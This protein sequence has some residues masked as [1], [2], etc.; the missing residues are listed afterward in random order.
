MVKIRLQKYLASC[1]IG[2]RRT[3]ERYIAEGKIKVDNDIITDQGIQIDP[4][5]NQIYFDGDKVQPEKKYWLMLN[6]PT[7]Y[8]C[9]SN[10]PQGRSS[11]LELIPS[12]FGRLYSVGR[13]DFMSEGLL[14]VTNDGDLAFK[15]S[16]PRYEIPKT[17]EVHTVE[18]ITEK[19][20]LQMRKGIS[21][22]KELL[23]ILDIHMKSIKKKHFCYIITLGE[24][25]HRHIRRMLNAFKI[26]IILLKRISHGPLKLGSLQKGKWRH[27]NREEI[28][29]LHEIVKKNDS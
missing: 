12:S 16:H 27:L 6:K 1:G 13:L 10:D 22:D 5:I 25:R 29:L 24:G 21:C 15:L 4:E 11:Y 19:H 9:S 20:I 28:I 26:H 3:C 23:K 18:Q 2:S 8:I 17:Y 14:L 7:H